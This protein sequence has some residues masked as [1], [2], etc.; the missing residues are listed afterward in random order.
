[1]STRATKKPSVFR[2]NHQ[3]AGRTFNGRK[4]VDSLYDKNWVAYRLR[5]LKVNPSCYRCG[6]Y[7]TVVDHI[8]PHKGNKELFE[9]LDNHI[10]LCSPCHNK[11]TGLFDR[12]YKIGSIPRQK[13]E[14]L[15]WER[16]RLCL[17]IKVIPLSSYYD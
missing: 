7:A 6:E 10:P 3:G 4:E 16:A 9:K 15:A 12:N 17:K 2:P 1:M 5:F 11:A 8:T 13:L 14:W